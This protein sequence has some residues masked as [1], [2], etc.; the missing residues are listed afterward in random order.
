M[1]A[2]GVIL[3]PDPQD[4][5][6]KGINQTE[7]VN[8]SNTWWLPGDAVVRSSVRYWHTGDPLTPDYPAIGMFFLYFVQILVPISSNRLDLFL[9]KS[10]CLLK[11]SFSFV[12]NVSQLLL[13]VCLF[14]LSS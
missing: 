3:Y 6:D 10:N 11:I 2:L 4:Y 1:G 8:L 12:L 9:F 7:N 14:Y 13:F 5:T